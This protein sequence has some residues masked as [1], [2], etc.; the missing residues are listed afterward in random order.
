MDVQLRQICDNEELSRS[1][2]RSQLGEI[3]DLVEN[4][5]V[6]HQAD[7][8]MEE[9]TIEL[10]QQWSVQILT[11]VSDRIGRCRLCT[12]RILSF[13]VSQK[14]TVSDAM[15]QPARVERQTR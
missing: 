1:E 7:E 9:R 13:S 8:K 10:S 6:W 5:G 3:M 2:S 15:P 4:A 12:G 11:V 14:Q